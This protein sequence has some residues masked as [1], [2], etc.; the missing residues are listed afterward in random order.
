MLRLRRIL[1][2]VDFS[3]SSDRATAYAL[4]LARALGAELHVLHAYQ[5]PV[6]ALPDGG[7]IATAEL[8]TRITDAANTAMDR[9]IERHRAS[10]VP[11]APH[12][13]EGAPHQCIQDEAEKLGAELIVIGT[14]GRTGVARLLLGSVAEKVVRT[15]RVPVLTVP[16]HDSDR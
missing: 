6:I 11:I 8:V 16:G 5:I 7:V 2:P 9:L 13:A 10:A 1:N 3:E 15:S 12:V 14:H 4:D